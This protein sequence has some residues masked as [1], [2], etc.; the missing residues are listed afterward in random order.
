MSKPES[1]NL[2]DCINLYL[3]KYNKLSVILKDFLNDIGIKEN[4]LDSSVKNY[5]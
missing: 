5:E 1:K 4:L 2:D 3:K